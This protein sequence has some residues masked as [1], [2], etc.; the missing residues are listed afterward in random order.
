MNII[1]K[2]LY[3]LNFK[4]LLSI[5]FTIYLKDMTNKNDNLVLSEFSREFKCDKKDNSFDIFEVKLSLA[6]IE[7]NNK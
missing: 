1:L 5:L 7:S 4:K 6:K 3:R 2:I